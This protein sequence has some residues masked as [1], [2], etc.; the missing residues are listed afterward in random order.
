MVI[1]YKQKNFTSNIVLTN[2]NNIVFLDNG[3]IVHIDYENYTK[4]KQLKIEDIISIK[5]N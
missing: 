3:K 4:T 1:R 5:D 2:A